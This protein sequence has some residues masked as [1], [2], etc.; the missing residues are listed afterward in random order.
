LPTFLENPDVTF[1]TALDAERLGLDG[2][3]VYDHM[4]PIGHPNQP[5]ISALIILGSLTQITERLRLGTLVSRVGLV[6]DQLLFSD[7]VTLDILSNN[8]LIAGLGTGDKK[9]VIEN[10]LLN[11]KKLTVPERQNSLAK[12][13]LQLSQMGVETWVGAGLDSTNKIA[14]RS[15][16]KLNF[17][18][19]SPDILQEKIST[20]GYRVVIDETPGEIY[21]EI[22]AAPMGDKL[23]FSAN[24]RNFTWAGHLPEDHQ[25]AAAIYH[26]L[27]AIGISWVVFYV[28]YNKKDRL[29]KAFSLLYDLKQKYG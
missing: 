7:M 15:F 10:Q 6:G 11:I 22:L 3:F 4:W 8:R 24:A 19:V 29:Q 21:S 12:I 26:G 16:S 9:S 18:D 1:E 14:L 5:A 17:W 2:V 27:A 28:K 25:E 23:S 13:A 20:Y